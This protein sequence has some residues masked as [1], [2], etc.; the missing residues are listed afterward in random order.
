MSPLYPS[1][2][3]VHLWGILFL[4]CSC[5]FLKG[6][7]TQAYVKIILAI[8][9]VCNTNVILKCPKPTKGLSITQ[10]VLGDY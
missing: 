10:I 1:N 6:N 5:Q 3:F 8:I 2:S 4:I 7:H 9:L